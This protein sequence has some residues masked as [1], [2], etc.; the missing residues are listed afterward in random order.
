MSVA[1]LYMFTIFNH[2]FASVPGMTTGRPG[3]AVLRQAR[4]GAVVTTLLVGALFALPLGGMAVMFDFSLFGRGAMAIIVV[5][6]GLLSYSRSA[7]GSYFRVR[8]RLAME[9][10]LP[11]RLTAF[12]E[13]AHRLGVLRQSGTTYQFRHARLRD[14]LVTRA[15][16][17]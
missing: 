10:A 17:T 14:R 15:G 9:G 7:F 1:G 8:R 16:N 3:K 4:R 11:W 12:L 2:E 13:D 6:L 5:T